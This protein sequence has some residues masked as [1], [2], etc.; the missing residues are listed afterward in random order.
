[1]WP[2]AGE[3][4][5]GLARGVIN[6]DGNLQRRTI[7]NAGFKMAI[8]QFGQNAPHAF[9]GIIHHMA[10]IGADGAKPVIGNSAA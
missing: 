5:H 7:I 4:N 2:G 10:H 1:M 6:A 3:I 9:F 8:G